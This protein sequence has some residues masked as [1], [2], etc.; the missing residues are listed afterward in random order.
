MA[1]RATKDEGKNINFKFKIRQ[2]KKYQFIIRK[3]QKTIT[4][5][6]KENKKYHFKI[7]RFSTC[8]F[9]KVIS[10]D[11]GATAAEAEAP[12]SAKVPSTPA[13]E[14]ESVAALFS[15][16]NGMGDGL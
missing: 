13:E 1:G 10:E 16:Q 2:N 7:D 12:E 6:L 11:R 9:G 3:K 4:L 14:P 8:C 15:S 5:K